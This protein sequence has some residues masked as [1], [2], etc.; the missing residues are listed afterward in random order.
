MAPEPG[1]RFILLGLLLG[2]FLAAL[3]QTVVGTS[4]P[5]I[6]GELGGLD[7]IA[8]L[9]SAYMLGSTIVVPLAGKLS[10]RLGRRP[11]FLAGMG[12]FL[13]GSMLCGL[14]QS[15]DQLILFRFVQ[16]IGGGFIFPVAFA[17]VAD[18]YS[19]AERGRV[20]GA[21][22]AVW[23]VSSVIGPLLGGLIVDNASWRWVFYVNVP[24]G[25]L[26]IAVTL[27]HFPRVQARRDSPLDV[28]GA[29][30]LGLALTAFLLL[31]LGGGVD[32]PWASPVAVALALF[33]LATTALFVREETRAAD[34]LLPLALLRDRVV[35]WSLLAVLL[36]GVAMFGIISYLPLFIQGVL[37]ESATG[38]GIALIPFTLLIVAGSI[39]SGRALAKT[40]YRPWI[41]AGPLLAAAGLFLLA[42]L[43]PGSPMVEAVAYLIVA[44]LGLGFTL[45]T[46]MVAVQNVV[47][48]RQVG[49]ATAAVSLARTLGATLGVTLLGALL[50]QRLLEELPRRVPPEVLTSLQARNAI[51]L[52]EG[53]LRP[54]VL[55]RLDPAT[56]ASL[57]EG[58]AASITPLFLAAGLASAL[59]LLAASRVPGMRLKGREEYFRLAPGEEPQVAEGGVAAPV[60]EVLSAVRAAGQVPRRD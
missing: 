20:Q 2:L 49:T 30:L 13:V 21:L 28:R 16:G 5:R 51:E 42:R 23:G 39:V 7:R 38:S 3:D 34:P 25:A 54:E 53:L 48:P 31:A 33:S 26:A 50:N 11:I 47:P 52:A 55:A 9:F 8:W 22:S 15:M 4:L 35:G 6:V 37:G 32:F 29:A 58:L 56:I 27:R 44:G 59:A 1:Q 36:L 10:D 41:L 43:H 46:F 45:A 40:G 18:L 19:P 60:E 57:L 12:T 14:A 17:T 24:V